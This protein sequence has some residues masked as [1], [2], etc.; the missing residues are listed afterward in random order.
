[1]AG[2]IR[3]VPAIADA[4]RHPDDQRP[5]GVHARQRV[6]PRRVA[7][8]AACSSPPASAPTASPAPAASA[9]RWRRWIVDGEPELDLWKM[10]IR[11]FGPQ[12]RSRAYTLAR[13][14]RELRDLLRHP[15]PERGA[16]GRP[17]AARCRRRTRDSRRSAPSF[18]EK[19]GVG[20]PEL[21]RAERGG[22]GVATREPRG[23]P[24]AR[25]GGRALVPGDRG[26]GAGDAA[27]RPALFDETS[28]A[29]IEVVG[30]GR[31]RRSCSGC[32]P[33]TSTGRSAAIT[34]TQLLNRR[35]GIECDLTVT[36]VTPRPLPARDRDRVRQPRPRLDPAPRCRD[37]GSVLHQRRHVGPRLLRAVGAARPRHPR[38]STTTDDVSDAAFPYL[39]ARAITRRR[40]ARLRAAGHVRRRARLGA[41]RARRVRRARCGT[42]C[43]RRA[44]A[45]RWS[46]AAT[47]RSTPCG[48]RRAT[49]PGPPTSR[50]RRRRTRRASASRSR[51][52]S[53]DFLGRDALVAA[54]R[55]PGPRKRLRCLVLDDPRSVCLG[56]E[57][58]RVERRDRRPG[59]LR[60]LRLRV[61][62]SI[63]YAY[64]PPDVADR[65][66]GRGRG[67]RDVGRLR[68]GQGA[69]V[70]PGRLADPVVSRASSAP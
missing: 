21:V 15:L 69:A 44:A 24:A 30:S 56:N 57:P 61:E 22:A 66:P 10:D 65:R 41:V 48:S 47:G 53:G 7:T 63:A 13:S 32:A 11:R 20:A 43:G 4:R 9:A 49:A 18:G 35:G 50:P 51:S 19:A 29:K 68:G 23:A 60:R 52:T 40:R 42:R 37:D 17:A 12:Y 39:T 5:R 16:P 34:Y 38:P 3:R 25:L 58:V 62:R 2:A 67:V 8:S 55:A 46:P 27:R 6:H 31:A 26:R 36:R 45:R 28:F 64:L 54:T 14:D 33:T 59:D 70:R 1:M